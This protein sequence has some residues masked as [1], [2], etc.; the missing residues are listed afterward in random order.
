MVFYGGLAQGPALWPEVTI[1]TID[2]VLSENNARTGHPRCRTTIRTHA[3][4]LRAFFRFAEDHGWSRPGVAA[5]IVAP[6][7]Y[8][9]AALPVGP[10]WKEQRL[11]L[12]S[13]EGDCPADLRDRALLLMLSAYGLRVGEVCA[14][15]LD[16]IDWEAETLRVRRPKTGHVDLGHWLV[17]NCQVHERDRQVR[18]AYL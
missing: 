15:Q 10:S 3:D 8:R 6:R 9:D 11:L 16:D 14:L 4:A 13:T 12:A 2:R 7:V 18:G 17:K 1:A 5:A